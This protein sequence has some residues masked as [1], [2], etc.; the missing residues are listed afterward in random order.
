MFIM[1]QMQLMSIF[2]STENKISVLSDPKTLISNTTHTIVVFIVFICYFGQEE[3]EITPNKDKKSDSLFQVL[4]RSI[5]GE[6][7]PNM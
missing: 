1:N 4:Q 2:S 6:R 5:T 3:K 7:E